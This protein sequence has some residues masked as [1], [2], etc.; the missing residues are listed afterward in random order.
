M[1][2]PTSEWKL[3]DVLEQPRGEFD[4]LEV[5]G[6]MGLDLS[7][8]RVKESDVRK[9]LTVAISALA[10]TGGGLLIFGMHDPREAWQ[11]DDGGVALYMK[12]PSTRE[13]LE[14]IIPNIVD[15]PLRQFDVYAITDSQL[16]DDRGIIIVEIGD[17]D[18]APHQAEDN[19]YYG[20]VVGKSR[21]L[22][23]RLVTDILSRRRNPEIALALAV[24]RVRT[25]RR[26]VYYELHVTATNS[27][28]I[29]C[30]VRLPL[31]MALYPSE[32]VLLGCAG[33][34][35]RRGALERTHRG[36]WR[37]SGLHR[38][39]RTPVRAAHAR[40]TGGAGETAPALTRCP[41]S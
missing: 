35:G 3:A 21:P 13:W 15:P 23:H 16:A 31:G 22:G 18:L 12:R 29:P 25:H 11:V 30:R 9:Q 8:E 1:R 38:L 32:A 26:E 41:R 28:P 5:K 36:S 40:T 17:S 2:K 19:R 34:T 6:R 27:I 10:N 24:V 4:W 20:R 37:G 14:G 7:V 39:R 33:M